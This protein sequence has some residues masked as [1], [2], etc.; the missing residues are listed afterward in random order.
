MARI[1]KDPEERRNEILDTA[2]RLF[3][4]KGFIQTSVSEIV[5]EIGVAQGTFY[6]YF[7]TKEDIL[8]AIIDRYTGEITAGTIP[9]IERRDL[10]LKQKLEKIAAVEINVN[11]KNSGY[12]H[13]I[14][15]ADIHT[16]IL[17]ALAGKLVPFYTV[18]IEAGI[19]SGECKTDYP[20]ETVESMV[21]SSHILFDPGLF[22]RTGEEFDKCLSAWIDS[23]EKT[24]GMEKG[25]L[26]GYEKVM[27]GIYKKL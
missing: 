26:L 16:R 5:K 10:D 9:I 22:H 14:Q 1:T 17:T 21:V 19:E 4:E 24:L 20:R 8:K 7:K 3:I 11:K 2:Q 25:A 6:Y 23:I 15:S 12:L 18:L 13:S 27:K